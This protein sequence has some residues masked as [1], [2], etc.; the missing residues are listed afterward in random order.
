MRELFRLTVSELRSLSG[1]SLPESGLELT[2]AATLSN[3]HP[4]SIVF[5]TTLGNERIQ[6]LTRAHD[7]LLLLPTAEAD[8][9]PAAIRSANVIAWVQN[10]RL[11]YARI[12][13]AVAVNLTRPGCLECRGGAW[14][15]TD[16]DIADD[17]LIEPGAFIDHSVSIC[18]GTRISTG[19]IIRAYSSI[20]PN[21]VVRDGAA[22][23]VFGFAYERD[24]QGVPVPIPHFGGVRTGRGA[25]IGSF[26]TI[27]AGTIDPT[28]L[29]DNVKVDSLVHIAHNCEIGDSTLVIA[30]AEISGSVRVGRDCWIGPNASIIEG[31]SVGDGSVIG[32]GAAVLKDVD[33]L[34]TVAGN[35]AL[36][37]SLVSRR[38]RALSALVEAYY[39]GNKSE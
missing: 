12:M 22:V 8:L 20:G 6:L 39:S 34:T 21:S 10:P 9:L 38:N 29:G 17:V 31:R 27:C 26:S 13:N 24:E 32:L 16:A 25:D 18:S 5:A 3:V 2:R 33:L 28:V 37:T 19:A 35:P 36:S 23:G 11:S 7:C 4:S 15:S 14:V 1:E 30:C